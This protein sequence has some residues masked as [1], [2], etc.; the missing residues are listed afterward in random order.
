[1]RLGAGHAIHEGD[2]IALWSFFAQQ[3]VD[4]IQRPDAVIGADEAVIHRQHDLFVVVRNG[5]I[6]KSF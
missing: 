1:M 2:W 6:V 3:P 4:Q 5:H